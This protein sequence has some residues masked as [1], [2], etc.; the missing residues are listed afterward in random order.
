MTELRPFFDSAPLLASPASLVTRLHT[1]GYLFLRG[2]L[3]T[4]EV[5]A[6][7]RHVLAVADRADWLLP[8]GTEHPSPPADPQAAV[9]D[10]DP[11]NR[12][13]HRT[14]WTHRNASRG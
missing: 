11:A 7:R 10:P 3:P 8:A 4:V 2:I 13:V 1:D 12:R 14:M 6:V 5:A 9:W